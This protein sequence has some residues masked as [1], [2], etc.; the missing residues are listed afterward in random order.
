MKRKKNSTKERLLRESTRQNIESSDKIP[1]SK[2]RE[3]LG[4]WGTQYTDEQVIL[5]RDW[6]YELA[7]I[8]YDECFNR[9]GV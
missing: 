6:F 8:T 9:N 5:I 3:V 4:E 7:A 1:L 2:C